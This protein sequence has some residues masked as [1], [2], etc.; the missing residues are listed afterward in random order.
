MMNGFLTNAC[1][2]CKETLIHKEFARK[3]GVIP[4]SSTQCEYELI[5][6]WRFLMGFVVIIKAF[7]WYS[8]T[9][10]DWT[11]IV[12]WRVVERYLKNKHHKDTCLRLFITPCSIINTIGRKNMFKLRMNKH[13]LPMTITKSWEV[14][15]SIWCLLM[16]Y[17]RIAN[18]TKVSLCKPSWYKLENMKTKPRNTHIPYNNMFYY[19]SF[20][21]C[22]F[23][24]G[25]LSNIGLK[26]QACHVL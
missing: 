6:I 23:N 5:G 26:Q 14:W 18:A 21:G 20:I 19:V 22:H 13:A 24:L 25:H 2:T 9:F 12:D 1:F 7:K 11:S 15:F 3:I 10:L 16:L 8:V 4:F 17:R